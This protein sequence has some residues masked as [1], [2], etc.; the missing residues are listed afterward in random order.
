MYLT[1]NGIEIYETLQDL[2]K[3]GINYVGEYDGNYYITV[4]TDDPYDNR[5]WVVNKETSKV[6][7]MSFTTFIVEDIDE[8]A[9]P[10]NPE[11]LR[12]VS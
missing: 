1:S 5:V 10:V 7:H 3:K 2:L 6:S 9:K 11:T 4:D 8:K 12:R